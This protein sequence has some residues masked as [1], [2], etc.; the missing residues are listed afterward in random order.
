MIGYPL[1]HKCQNLLTADLTNPAFSIQQGEARFGGIEVSA[2]AE[3]SDN[4]SLRY[5][6]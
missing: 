4:W 6:L 2:V 1:S 3:L 5:C